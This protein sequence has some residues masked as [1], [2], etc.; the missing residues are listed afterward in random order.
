MVQIKFCSRPCIPTTSSTPSSMASE[1]AANVSV[2]HKESSTER[3]DVTLGDEEHVVWIEV[4]SEPDARSEESNA[5]GD[6][7][8]S[9]DALD[10]GG[11]VKIP[12]DAALAGIS[13]DFGQLKVTKGHISDL[14]SS[15]RFFP[16]GFARPPSIESIP[17]PSEDEVVVFEDF[18]AARLRIPPHHVLLDI[19]HKFQVQLHQ[20]TPN[21]IVHISKF[22]WLS[23]LAEVTLMLKFS[24]ITM[25]CI[26][27][28]RR[29]ILRGLRLSSLRSLDAYPFIRLDLEIA[30]GLL[31]PRGTNGLVVGIAIGST[32]RYLRSKARILRARRLIL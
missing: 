11:C 22:T 4:T 21:P 29:F 1:D 6:T 13:F 30:L 10:N 3:L 19:L 25:S 28:T 20:L 26:I 27:K 23:L 15:S 14:K 31:K 9:G 5:S 18:F 7:G 24:L 8:D 32:A 17:I 12:T 2:G 16:I